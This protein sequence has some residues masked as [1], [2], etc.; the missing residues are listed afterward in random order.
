MMLRCGDCG[1][2]AMASPTNEMM[3]VKSRLEW[4]GHPQESPRPRDRAE[5][6]RAKKA[7]CPSCKW[8]RDQK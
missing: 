2:I 8:K 1:R 7:V 3:A 5:L 4:W 6:Y